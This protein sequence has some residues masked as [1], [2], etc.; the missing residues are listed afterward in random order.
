MPPSRSISAKSVLFATIVFLAVAGP[1]VAGQ[2]K[3]SGGAIMGRIL[4]PSA[5]A[6]AGARVTAINNETGLQF[7][8]VT[9]SEGLYDFPLLRVGVYTLRVHSSGFKTI[10]VRGVTVDVAQTT[11]TDTQ[12]ELGT[13]SQLVVVEAAALSVRP[14]E[15]SVTTLVSRDFI[16]DLPLSGRRY[17][18]FALL[19]PNVVED[20][21]SGHLS[22][23]G[24]QGSSQSGYHNGNGA[25]SFTVDGAN[26]TSGFSGDARGGTNVP[27]IFGQQSID[28]FQVAVT[29]YAAAY[30]AAGSG[31]V[32]TV[33]KSGADVFHADLFYYLRHSATGANDA[34]S[35]S[36]GFPKSLNVLQQFGADFGGPI[37]PGKLWFYFDYEEQ[38]QKDPVRTVDPH[39]DE[40][41]FLNVASGTPLP[42]AN[43]PLP[44]PDEFSTAPAPGDPNYPVYLQQVS[45][46]LGAI[47]SSLGE[48]QRRRDDLVLF[49]KLDWQA[50]HADHFVFAHNYNKFDSPFGL[51]AFNPVAGLGLSGLPNSSV[52]DHHATISWNHLVHSAL[53][54]D[55]HLSFL[56]D[57]QSSTANDV[58]APTSSS[59]LLLAVGGSGSFVLGSPPNTPQVTKEFQW[60]FGE[61][62]DWSRGRHSFQF[63][64][65][66]NRTQVTDLS[67][68][69]SHGFYGFF[70][71]ADFA[72]GAY[73]FY[74]QT[75]G[76]PVF[77]LAVPSYGFYA[78]DKFRALPKLTLDL[79]LR[80]DFQLFPQPPANPAFPLA[81]QFPNRY[82]NLSPRI[83][84]AYEATSKTVLRGGFGVF[85]EMLNAVNYENSVVTNGSTANRANLLALFDFAQPANQQSPTFPNALRDVTPSPAFN[86]SLIHPDFR[87]PYVLAASLEVQEKFGANTDFTM[88]TLW[89]H[90]VH[91]ISSTAFDLNLKKP[92]GT[93]TY[94]VCPPG[95]TVAPCTG[96]I[97]ELP[98]LD[99]V[100]L[101]GQE[102]AVD[103]NLGQLNALI[104]P[105]LNHYNSLYARMQRRVSLGLSAIVSYTYSR[106]IQSNGLD[107]NNQFDF[108]NTRGPSLL[109]QRHRLSAAVVYRSGTLASSG[110]LRGALSNW[111]LSTVTQVNSGRP[112]SALLNTSCSSSTLSFDNCDGLSVVLN[113][114][115]TLQST[116]NTFG[117][118]SSS[119]AAG[120]NSFY[121][122]SIFEVNIGIARH[123]RFHENH[124]LT[125]E[126]QAFNLFNR[127][128]F[129]VQNGNGVN[130]IQ[131]NPIGTTC[132]DGMTLNQLCYLVPN[133]DFGTHQSISQQHGPRIF[134]FAL[135][136]HF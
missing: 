136:Y 71:L 6:V 88:G 63:G 35:K 76:N 110:L 10:E 46:A 95:T 4:D 100:L 127:A 5:A 94:V 64:F 107:F 1:G 131:Y 72:T 45:N 65:D 109:E 115:A 29:P 9:N 40:S 103:A 66:F 99:A 34:A 89:T 26:S 60:E 126:A 68:S 21:D 111:T 3:I 8:A 81:G 130:A 61:R 54:N 78:Q 119:P 125:L 43:S 17:T 11:T 117:G 87:T 121:G 85:H 42:P 39:A 96:H 108:S 133:P 114:S 20:G 52:R 134:Q 14:S 122:P 67:T 82:K 120:M 57:D 2:N 106:N 19:A 86:I 58:P 41:L 48:L 13:F 93:T 16:Q 32:N 7:Q 90:G 44:V 30:G 74:L 33:T 92:T 135:L 129:Y 22:I 24:Q 51:F 73:A 55:L 18:D 70:T 113:N 23:A 102:G 124:V 84:F 36:Q 38:R 37:A 132:G 69:F 118:S 112:F 50:T 56:R 47:D 25:N 27:Y 12:L 59:I 105:G 101:E 91:L 77:S 128:N 104:S 123:F 28:Q 80:E 62:L 98:N 15:S 97:I 49:S 79:G 116:G 75:V 83:G 31:F 53:L